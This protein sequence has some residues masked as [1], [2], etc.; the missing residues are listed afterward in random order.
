MR[1]EKPYQT[2]KKAPSSLPDTPP[3]YSAGD[4]V[5]HTKFG[6]GTVVEIKKGKKD[7]EVTVSFENA[8]QKK[9][10]AGFAKLE[11]I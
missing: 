6:I 1:F 3:A 5:Q 8:G 9:L 11:K 10:L 7:Y 4:Q 2:Q